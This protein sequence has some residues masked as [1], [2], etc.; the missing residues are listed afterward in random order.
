MRTTSLRSTRSHS[1]CFLHQTTSLLRLLLLL[2]VALLLQRG[3]DPSLL[4]KRGHSALELARQ[5]GHQD[6]AELLAAMSASNGSNGG[7]W[8]DTYIDGDVSAKVEALTMIRDEPTKGTFPSPQVAE[9]E[10]R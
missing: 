6:T 1:S 2:Q 8:V 4:T 10:R 9:M 5:K 7:A 3:A